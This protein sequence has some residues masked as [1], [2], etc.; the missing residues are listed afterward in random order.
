MAPLFLFLFVGIVLGLGMGLLKHEQWFDVLSDLEIGML[1]AI[2]GGMAFILIADKED[3]WLGALAASLVAA[4]LFLG[5]FKRVV[6]RG[7]T[8]LHR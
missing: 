5:L 7:P 2:S 6:S 8:P 4:L 1:G 3:N